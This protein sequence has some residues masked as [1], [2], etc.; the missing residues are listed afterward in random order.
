MLP[1]SLS[2]FVATLGSHGWKHWLTVAALITVGLSIGDSMEHSDLT[3]RW[4]YKLYQF[5]NHRARGASHSDD[6]SIV[7]IG[8][9][10]YWK[11]DLARRSPLNAIG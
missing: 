3:L 1:S 5:L 8:D 7:R 11:G 10:E 4:Q 6:I 2:K 9:E